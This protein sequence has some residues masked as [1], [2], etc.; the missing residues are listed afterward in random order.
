MTTSD[1]ILISSLS[2]GSNI[3]SI[4][5]STGLSQSVE[6]Q[7][8]VVG[9]DIIDR[10]GPYSL[11][12]V[13]TLDGKNKNNFYLLINTSLVLQ[14]VP[15]ITCNIIMN[16]ENYTIVLIWEVYITVHKIVTLISFSHLLSPLVLLSC[17]TRF[18]TT[19]QVH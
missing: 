6:Y 13:F 3:T 1:N 12:T 18:I 17:T 8:R 15:L 2:T 10:L 16:T 4:K 11:Y 5:I 9:S 19:Y 7:Y 14:A